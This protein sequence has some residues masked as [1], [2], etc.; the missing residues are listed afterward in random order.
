MLPWR[1]NCNE[2]INLGIMGKAFSDSGVGALIID[3]EIDICYL[4]RNILKSKQISSSYVCSLK[5]A[6]NCLMT[7]LPTLI[8]LDNHLPDGLGVEFIA[9]IKEVL[10]SVV[11]VLISGHDTKLYKDIAMNAGAFCF[12]DKPFTTEH[13]HSTL[14]RILWE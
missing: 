4:L 14:D 8:F 9:H 12:I 3:D 2:W 5:D 7:L 10:P 11:I 1:Q 13:I 6:K